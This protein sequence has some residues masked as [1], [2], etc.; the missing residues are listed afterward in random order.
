MTR[1]N[2]K[3]KYKW[4]LSQYKYFS[5]TLLSLKRNICIIARY[6]LFAITILIVFVV[7]VVVI[8]AVYS[9]IQF[10]KRLLY[11]NIY[12]STQPIQL[13]IHNNHIVSHT[14]KY[15]CNDQ[16]KYVYKISHDETTC[17]SNVLCL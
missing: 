12:I 11:I 7:V 1:T 8:S 13:I 9:Y 5:S 15:K 6:V 17:L 4:P 3:R 10:L 16:H 2:V 14:E